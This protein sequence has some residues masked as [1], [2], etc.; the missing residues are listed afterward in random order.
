MRNSIELYVLLNIYCRRMTCGMRDVFFADSDATCTV[1]NRP[2][3][4]VCKFCVAYSRTCFSQNMNIYRIPVFQ[5]QFPCMTID[6]F[7]T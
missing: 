2:N 6:M 5:L 1:E 3:A 4:N 7:L